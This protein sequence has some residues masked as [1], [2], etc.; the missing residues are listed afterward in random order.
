MFFLRKQYFYMASK[1]WKSEKTKITVY[2]FS[3]EPGL[4]CTDRGAVGVVTHLSGIC[5]GL[6]LILDTFL[7]GHWVDL[8]LY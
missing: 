4:G 8:N 3:G 6:C 5:D 2:W 7:S 1:S